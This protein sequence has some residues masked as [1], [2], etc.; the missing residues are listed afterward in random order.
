MGD[1]LLQTNNKGASV[2]GH[3]FQVLQ[4]LPTKTVLQPSM[5]RCPGEGCVRASF[6]LSRALI[7]LIT[8]LVLGKMD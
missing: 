3:V 7:T 6:A 5:P 8:L 4:C 1:V 2:L